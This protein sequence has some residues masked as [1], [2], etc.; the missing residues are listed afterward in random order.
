MEGPLIAFGGGGDDYRIFVV[1]S[2]YIEY[3]GPYT[4]GW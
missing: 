4:P 1:I 2:A 3:E